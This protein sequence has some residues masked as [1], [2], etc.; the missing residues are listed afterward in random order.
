V[1]AGNRNDTGADAGTDADDSNQIRAFLTTFQTYVTQQHEAGTRW[2]LDAGPPESESPLS[3]A[4]PDAAPAAPD[5]APA[6]PDAAP[7]APRTPAP[8]AD[9]TASPPPPVTPLPPGDS[10]TAEPTAVRQPPPASQQVF[11]DACAAFV[12][13]TLVHIAR[14]REAVPAQ[15]DIFTVK[16]EP[17]PSLDPAA[18][19]TALAELAAEVAAC[20][21]CE[22]HG[23]RTQT[24]FGAGNSD[25]DLVL[26]GEAPGVEEDRQ[27]LPFVG[28]SGQLLTE[29]LKA[30][31]FAREDVYICNI[32]KCHPPGN[33]DPER[34]EVSSCEAYLQRQLE[35]IEPRIILCL[36][37]VA[38]QTLLGTTATLG[39]LRE[40]VHFYVGIPVMATYHPAALL[41]N[42]HMKRP[43]WDDV[44]KVRA[45]HDAL[46]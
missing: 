25:A 10:R 46:R 34:E 15:G 13:D 22:L 26:I 35:I 7:A 14:H 45:L 40:S 4:A 43:C 9:P 33:R 21:L 24:V 3:A 1:S 2:Y 6:A 17:P 8:G 20:R 28:R 39:A 38:A 19:Q 11:T 27:G 42:A 44:R 29:I 41:R 37:R 18:K 5:A 30:I 12:R 36:G 31:G 23:G 32:L 16:E